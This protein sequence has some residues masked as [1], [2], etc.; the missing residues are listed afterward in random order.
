MY[1]TQIQKNPALVRRRDIW[2]VDERCLADGSVLRPIQVE[3]VVALA[4]ILKSRGIQSIAVAYL[5]SYANPEHEHRTKEILSGLIPELHITISSDVSLQNREYERANTAVINAYL[6]PILSEYV[7]DLQRALPKLGID[8]QLWIMQSDGGLSSAERVAA[9]PVNTVESGPAAGVLMAA[10]QGEL[11]GEKAVISFDMGGTTAKV[12]VVRDGRPAKIRQQEVGAIEMRPG[13]GLPVEISAIDLV[14]IGAGGGSVAHA[15]LGVLN[16][17]PESAGSDPGPACYAKGGTQPTVTDANLL[18]GY[19]N[20]EYFAGGRLRLD[21]A[22]ARTAVEQLG[23]RLGLD[24]IRAAWGIHELA[25]LQMEH[26]VR[27]ISIGRDLDPR[28]FVMVCMGGAAPAHASRLA[29]NLGIRRVIVPWGA[30]VGSAVGLLEAQES[31]EVGTAVRVVLDPNDSAA[32][33]REVLESLRDKATAAINDWGSSSA[34]FHASVGMRYVGQGWEL[35][36]PVEFNPGAL[37]EFG[38]RHPKVILDT[39]QEQYERTYGYRESLPVEAVTWY[40]NVVRRSTRAPARRV[41]S[42]SP[43]SA[44]VLKGKRNAFFPEAGLIQV[45]VYDRYAM[46]EGHSIQGPCFVEEDETTT[47]LLPGDRGHCDE[48]LNLV[49]DFEDA[50]HA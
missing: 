10:Q 39:F 48:K 27:M 37:A 44:E 40:L 22:L 12:A 1:D 5:H 15:T 9:F 45:P 25:T 21:E 43:I 19:L 47:V 42:S 7:M 17:G 29:R 6:A 18:L 36:V 8:A 4:E 28:D 30:G 11:A 26:A 3:E 20:P 33:V 35:E 16:L 34:D 50:E 23:E 32:V 31:V 41:T 38:S 24:T 14:E 46:D 13:S 2:E 49:V